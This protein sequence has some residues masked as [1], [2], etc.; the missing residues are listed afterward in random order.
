MMSIR[1]F[2]I[3]ILVM[4]LE[5][6]C[7]K[8]GNSPGAADPEI[9]V[10]QTLATGR[11]QDIQNLRYELSFAIPPAAAEPIS[12]RAAIRFNTKDTSR[13]LVLDFEPGGTS[14]TSVSVAGKPS[15]FRVANGHI[16]IPKEEL[17]A[18]EN[19]IEIVFR[20]GD[21]SSQPQS[22]F[23]VHAV[24]AGTRASR[25]SM[26]R[27]AGSESPIHLGTARCPPEWQAVSNGAE[28]SREPLV[29]RFEFVCR[30]A[31]DSNVPVCICRRQISDRDRGAQ[32]S[33]VRMFH[34]ETDAEKVARN[35][36]DVFD[37]HASALSWLENYTRIP[38]PFGKFD[39]VLIPS[40]QFGGMEHPGAIFYNASGMLL[41]ESATENQMLN[42][43]STIAHETAHMWFGDLVT[44][45]WFNDVWMKEV[46]AN[47]MAAKS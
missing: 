34:R 26:L 27:S 7:Q 36:D 3:L 17:I 21:A 9:G 16:I 29:R 2:I 13:P 20:A 38:Y 18:G 42:R 47:F 10:A 1:S 15:R 22:G 33:H 28:T 46:F 40:F 24:C 39:F 23:Y 19:T 31:T 25:I 11:A 14:L 45:R 4:A 43:A 35:R 37:L 6:G 41:D 44:M 12:A 8:N 30:D 5:S 32:W